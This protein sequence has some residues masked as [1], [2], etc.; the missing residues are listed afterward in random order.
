MTSDAAQV[1]RTAQGPP[2]ERPV[3]DRA[4]LAYRAG[5][6]GEAELLCQQVVT[7]RADLFDAFY[8]LA[9]VQAGL[10]KID[11]ALTTYERALRSGRTLPALISVAVACSSN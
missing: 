1:S 4:L 5:D 2:V 10:G 7:A 6:L 3:F 9:E 11:A 8:L